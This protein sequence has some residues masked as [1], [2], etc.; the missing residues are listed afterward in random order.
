MEASRTGELHDPAT[1]KAMA[2]LERAQAISTLSRTA[3][4]AHGGIRSLGAEGH[5]L[6][7]IVEMKKRVPRRLEVALAPPSRVGIAGPV[8][9]P[10]VEGRG[11]QTHLPPNP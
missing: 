11:A 2:V 6:H 10:R 9:T 3:M 7:R 1:S 4:T 5:P 8:A